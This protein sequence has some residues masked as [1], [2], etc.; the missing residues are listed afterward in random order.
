MED[1][2]VEMNEIAVEEPEVVEEATESFKFDGRKGLAIAGG[3]AAAGLMVFAVVKI[4]KACRDGKFNNVKAVMPWSEEKK[5]ARRQKKAAKD[6]IV[7]EAVV[8]NDE[9]DEK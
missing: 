7:V 9:S 6:D 1:V 4:V 3:A 5:E 2:M 8:I